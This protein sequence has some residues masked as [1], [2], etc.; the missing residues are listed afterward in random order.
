MTCIGISKYAR[1]FIEHSLTSIHSVARSEVCVCV[2]L[3]VLG[4]WCVAFIQSYGGIDIGA[5]DTDS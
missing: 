4:L 5:Y 2:C 3:C 1:I